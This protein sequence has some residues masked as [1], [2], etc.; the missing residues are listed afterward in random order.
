[1]ALIAAEWTRNVDDGRVARRTNGPSGLMSSSSLILIQPF[2]ILFLWFFK[3]CAKW[4]KRTRTD[5]QAKRNKIHPKIKWNKNNTTDKR[6]CRFHTFDNGD[7]TH[8]CVTLFDALRNSR[9]TPAHTIAALVRNGLPLT[10]TRDWARMRFRS[11]GVGEQHARCS[12]VCRCT[13]KN[14]RE[15]EGHKV[16]ETRRRA[17]ENDQRIHS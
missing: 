12:A 17:I 7:C 16:T 13:R 9:A 4:T 14:Q 5:E 1:M 10:G 2:Y 11:Y 3:C 15:E 8:M 6:K